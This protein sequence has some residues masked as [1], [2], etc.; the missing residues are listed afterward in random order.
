MQARVVALCRHYNVDIVASLSL[1]ILAG[2]KVVKVLLVIAAPFLTREST[3]SGCLG[4]GCFFFFRL[5]FTSFLMGS[6]TP[7]CSQI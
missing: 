6:F 3:K 1:R 7:G 5:D 2:P 4:A